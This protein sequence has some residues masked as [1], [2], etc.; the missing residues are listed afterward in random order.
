LK[1]GKEQNDNVR[2]SKRG[3]IMQQKILIVDHQ[4]DVADLL[5][6][7][8]RRNGYNVVVAS[9]GG[10]GLTKALTESPSLVVLEVELPVISGFEVCR[11][12]KRVPATRRLPIIMLTARASE[13]DRVK[14]LEA[15]ADDYVTK[16][17][18]L[19]EFALR[20]GRSIGRAAPIAPLKPQLRV[21]D[22]VLDEL[23]HEIRVRDQ[24]VNLTALEFRLIALLMENTGFVLQRDRLL[25][26]VWGYGS[27]V[28]TRTVDTHI[29]RLR[30][31]LGDAGS[32]IE[33][34][35]GIGYR[36]KEEGKAFDFLPVK[37]DQ[38]EDCLALT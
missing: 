5:G 32:A 28:T 14:G 2:N 7:T 35:R 29:M 24:L 26:R 16:P 15:G 27:A 22:F 6:G 33:T 38:E 21:G 34:V 8:L 10:S 11:Q 4:T 19:Q 30:S 18:S 9:D 17:F 37:I 1:N 13:Q 31:K 36:L 20:V 25:D 12:I 23:R 3:E